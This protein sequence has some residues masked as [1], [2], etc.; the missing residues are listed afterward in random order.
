MRKLFAI[1]VSA[2]LIFSCAAVLAEEAAADEN[3]CVY[4][5][6][7]VTGEKVVELYLTDNATGEKSEN[8]AGEEGL[9]P[10]AIVQLG[11]ENKEGYEVTLSFKTES[12][13]EAAFPTLHF[14]TVPLSLLPA[15]SED[16]ITGPTP[17]NFF[18]PIYTAHY[19]LCNMTGEKVTEVTF[20]NNATGEV[21]TAW[22]EFDEIE[23]LEPDAI[24]PA[25]YNC[26][27]DKTG[28]L[29]LT[30]TFKTESG[31]VG[32][33]PTLH[34]E[35][36][37]INLLSADAMTGATQISFSMIPEEEEKPAE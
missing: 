15:P 32:T 1:L 27:A 23:A 12:G 24:F 20:T 36:V 18:V 2:L 6:Y 10:F 30:L 13:Y 9:P 35:D 4:T 8:Y 33:F 11:G 34:F 21:Q 22:D 19:N 25:I 37:Q 7:N 31:Y 26:D 17:I 3:V 28:E 14:E 29:E 5:V 16:V